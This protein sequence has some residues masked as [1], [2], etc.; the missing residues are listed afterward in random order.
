M[1]SAAQLHGTTLYI[2]VRYPLLNATS[3]MRSPL[4]LLLF[5]SRR[6]IGERLGTSSTA[7]PT[8]LFLYNT[9]NR[10]VMGPFVGMGPP[11]MDIRPDAWRAVGRFPAQVTRQPPGFRTHK[12]VLVVGCWWLLLL[13]LVL[14]FVV[15]VH[16]VL[17]HTT[18]IREGN[19]VVGTSLVL[20]LAAESMGCT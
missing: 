6:H 10:T 3:G 12:Q 19:G 15:A 1:P 7:P 14:V 13:L 9:S 16:L 4:P 20:M 5:V 18:H 11:G 2:D 17:T 8:P